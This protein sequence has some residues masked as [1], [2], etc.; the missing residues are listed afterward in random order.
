M[1]GPL[2]AGKTSAVVIGDS[3]RW[4]D[5]EK[6]LHDLVPNYPLL[7]AMFG[8]AREPEPDAQL[9]GFEDG[10]RRAWEGSASGDTVTYVRIF[11][12]DPKFQ[13]E[14]REGGKVLGRV[15]TTFSEDGTLVKSRLTVPS[16]GARLDVSFYSST[17]ADSFPPGIWL[18]REP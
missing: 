10:S 1:A 16:R 12:K 3:A 6:S 2:G 17:A 14:V 11:G 9:R 8:V 18:R 7:W 15:E 4:V 5:P 13:A